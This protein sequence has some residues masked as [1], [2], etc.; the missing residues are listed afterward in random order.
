[1]LV[2]FNVAGDLANLLLSYLDANRLDANPLGTLE[3]ESEQ[4]TEIEDLRKQ[5]SQYNANSR[6]PFTDWW[7]A[8]EVIAKLYNKPHIGLEVGTYIEHSQ[9]GVLGSVSLSCEH[10]AV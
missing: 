7:Y 2:N 6:M 4:A 10:R 5:L 9:G 3:H 8:L 1:M